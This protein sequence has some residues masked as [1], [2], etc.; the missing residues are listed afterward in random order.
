M[1]EPAPSTLSL[2][3]HDGVLFVLLERPHARNAMTLQ[4][5]HELSTV[6]AAAEARDDL[7]VVVLRGAGGHF[8]AGADVKD[9]LRARAEPVTETHHPVAQTN[10]A[11]GH[12]CVTFARL[13]LPTVC[14][15]EGSVLGG[16]FGL[17]CAAD[18][19]LA[20][21]TASFGLPE[22]SIGVV[23]AQIAPFL[24]ERLGFSQA[25]RLALMG[26]EVDAKE[27]YAIGLVHELHAPGV[28][29]ERAIETLLARL[30]RGAPRATRVTKQLLLRAQRES[31]DSLI[32]HAAKVFATQLDSSEG[33]EGTLAF[34]EK[35]APA[36]QT[37]R[38]EG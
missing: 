33:A 3:E 23:P 7:R 5:V 26:G 1:N 35:R 38:S 34:V 29:L 27:A 16:G 13:S 6:L 4:M 14:V 18:L 8:C 2:S 37:R 30:L 31:A 21:E 24:V 12:L 17:A 32:E 36:W 20:D 25:K 28:A 11:F 10:A 22:T 9:L 15:L 19:A